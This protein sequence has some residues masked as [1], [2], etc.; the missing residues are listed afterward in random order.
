MTTTIPSTTTKNIVTHSRES[1]EEKPESGLPPSIAPP[2]TNHRN[3]TKKSSSHSKEIFLNLFKKSHLML[4]FNFHIYSC[5]INFSKIITF[6]I[7][8]IFNN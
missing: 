7:Y 3:S 6:T 4:K 8:L 1:N 2:S 5:N